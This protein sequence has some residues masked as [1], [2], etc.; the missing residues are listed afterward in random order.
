MVV[1][2]E[3]DQIAFGQQGA[4]GDFVGR[5]GAVEHE[6][7]FVGVVDFCSMGLCFVGRAFVYQQITQ[8][9]VGVA[10][11]GAEQGFAE[12]E[13]KAAAGRVFAEKLAALVAGAVE[14][15]VAVIGV[16]FEG[17]EKRRVE[18]VDVVGGGGVDELAVIEFLVER[19]FDHA[20]YFR[21]PFGGHALTVFDGGENRYAEAQA[22]DFFPYCRQIFYRG[23][24]GADVGEIGHVDVH[25]AEF[26]FESEFGAFAGGDFHGGILF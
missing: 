16:V 26:G 22:F 6:I 9:Y 2:V 17:A 8:A 20:V 19:E 14:S 13:E 11:V 24:H 5:R 12:I 7:G 23:N 1:A 21:Q 15:G 18:C 3:Q 25:H 4:D 10:G